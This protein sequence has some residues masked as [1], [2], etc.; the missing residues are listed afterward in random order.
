MPTQRKSSFVR[1]IPEEPGAERV[2][3]D[4]NGGWFLASL[5]ILHELSFVKC[6]T[7]AI[8]AENVGVHSGL[9][10]SEDSKIPPPVFWS[11]LLLNN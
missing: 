5:K 10:F 4:P 11:F 2:H 3:F 1:A 6:F 9:F 8:E 7:V